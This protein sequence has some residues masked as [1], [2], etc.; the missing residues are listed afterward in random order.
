M[1]SRRLITPCFTRRTTS[2]FASLLPVLPTWIAGAGPSIPPSNAIDD[3]LSP[4]VMTR[5]NNLG[6]V[7]MMN[8]KQLCRPPW[9]SSPA[10]A[11]IPPSP[12]SK[13]PPKSLPSSRHVLLDLQPRNRHIH[14]IT[15]REKPPWSD[16]ATSDRPASAARRRQSRNIRQQG[17]RQRFHGVVQERVSIRIETPLQ[18]AFFFA[19]D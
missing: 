6:H 2:W 17:C 5:M 16:V 3:H 8:G 11:L 1:C 15:S 9:S 18:F 19:R 4:F 7:M 14:E 13:P 12:T 10:G